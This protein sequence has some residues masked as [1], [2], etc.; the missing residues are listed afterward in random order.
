VDWKSDTMKNDLKDNTSRQVHDD[1][2]LIS[3]KRAL[4]NLLVTIIL[5]PTFSFLGLLLWE[6]SLKWINSSDHKLRFVYG[7]SGLLLIMMEIIIGISLVYYSQRSVKNYTKPIFKYFYNWLFINFLPKL[8]NEQRFK[9]LIII[10]PVLLL[11]DIEVFI[12]TITMIT[13]VLTILPLTK[14][15]IF[16]V[17]LGI[18]LLILI[19]GDIYIGFLHLRYFHW[20]ATGRPILSLTDFKNWQ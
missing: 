1:Y 9:T 15:Y 6:L 16:N 2:D 10:I 19:L 5:I 14:D 18:S 12:L 4:S 3:R 7:L 13:S 20:V 8:N 17:A 11:I